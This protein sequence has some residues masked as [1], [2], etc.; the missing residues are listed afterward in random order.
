MQV[1][2]SD[3]LTNWYGR[4]DSANTAIHAVRCDRQREIVLGIILPGNNTDMRIT[5]I[6]WLFDE[7]R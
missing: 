2:L 3:I 7:K 5:G 1:L 4:G 6:R